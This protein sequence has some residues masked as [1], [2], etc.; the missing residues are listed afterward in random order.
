MS[1]SEDAASAAASSVSVLN[2]SRE[3]GV[4]AAPRAV[5]G[6]SPPP[7]PPA[8][9][10]SKRFD[11]SKVLESS[12]NTATSV[13]RWKLMKA[14]MSQG[15]VLTSGLVV[16]PGRADG[17]PDAPIESSC[18]CSPLWVEMMSAYEDSITMR[19]CGKLG[20]SFRLWRG[21]MRQRREFFE[22]VSSVFPP[23]S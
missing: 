17:R 19:H 12:G 16:R 23:I 9:R 11:L 1:D 18:Q 3:F 7:P 6:F 2:G 10:H 22:Q 14:N 13:L 15:K 8:D 5:G 21:A 20:R 4:A